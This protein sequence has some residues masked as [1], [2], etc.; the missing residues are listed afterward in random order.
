M[1]AREFIV[2]LAPVD[3]P[4]PTG[5]SPFVCC[6]E[7]DRRLTQ[8]EWDAI[9][10]AWIAGDRKFLD[11]EA[12]EAILSRAAADHGTTSPSSIGTGKV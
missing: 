10:A 6:L 2:D 4:A 3:G 1:P 7:G 5:P 12:V 8:A 11:P 9:Y